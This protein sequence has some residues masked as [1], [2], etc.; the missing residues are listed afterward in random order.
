MS[1]L[2]LLAPAGLV[3]GCASAA[4]GN[5]FDPR[6]LQEE[7]G[8][9]RAPGV[10]VILQEGDA[11]CGAAALSMILASWGAPGFP[12]E[13][14]PSRSAPSQGI[15]AARLREIALSRGLRA[16]LLKGEAGDLE[17]QL[18]QE[19]PVLVGVA[20][21]GP[22]G[23]ARHYLVIV[24]LHPRRGLIVS[25]DPAAGWRV[26]PFPDFLATW[27]RAGRLMLLVFRAGTSINP[28][29]VEQD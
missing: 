16:Y 14:L 26:E 6:L 18:G 4:E 12:E 9:I 27:T 10:P 15:P 5:R 25:L 8:W 17:A 24:A 1:A 11:D 22:H 21:E 2:L 3:G 28:A 20:R 13:C 29:H 19:R 23:L 7:E